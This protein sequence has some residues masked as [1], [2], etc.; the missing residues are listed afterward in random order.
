MGRCSG[1]GRGDAEG[2]RRH[3]RRGR[4]GGHIVARRDAA[5]AWQRA[6]EG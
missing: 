3:R 4:A 6:G 2:V 5:G 1:S